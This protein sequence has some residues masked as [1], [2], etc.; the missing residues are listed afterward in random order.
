[1]EARLVGTELDPE[2]LRAAGALVREAVAP[3]DDVRASGTYRREV[4]ANLLLRLSQ[5]VHGSGCRCSCD[6]PVGA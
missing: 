1:M 2:T 5:V 6:G 4:A 3:I